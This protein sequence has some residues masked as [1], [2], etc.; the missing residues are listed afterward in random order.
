MIQWAIYINI[1]LAI[2]NL[3]PIPPLDGS[4]IL[5]SF[6]PGNAMY[7]YLS[8]GRFG[9]IFIFILLFL[10]GRFFLGVVSPVISFLYKIM[11]WWQFLI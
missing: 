4:N 3:I 11:T 6:L 9:F 5:A 7:R 2:F 1:F 8:L 10:G